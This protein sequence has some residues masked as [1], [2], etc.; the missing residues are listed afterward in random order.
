MVN[1]CAVDYNVFL[2]VDRNGNRAGV[3]GVDMNRVGGGLA[4]VVESDNLEAR[5]GPKVKVPVSVAEK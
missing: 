4:G 5:D 3:V 1:I 2:E